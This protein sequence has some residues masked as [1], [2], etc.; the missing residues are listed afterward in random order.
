LLE[1]FA[2]H[3]NLNE[4]RQLCFYLGIDFEDIPPAGLYPGGRHFSEGQQRSLCDLGIDYNAL[5]SEEIM[6]RLK[7]L[8][9][10][11]F[12]SFWERK[13]GNTAQIVAICRHIRHDAF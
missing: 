1:I 13:G 11:N 10:I 7:R 9:F 5:T 8:W 4:L 2:N 3:L 12:T 6:V